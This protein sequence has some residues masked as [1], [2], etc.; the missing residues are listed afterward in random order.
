[1]KNLIIKVIILLLN[2]LSINIYSQTKE[3]GAGVLLFMTFD[4]ENATQMENSEEK[5]GD[6]EKL[7]KTDNSYEIYYRKSEGKFKIILKKLEGLGVEDY[8]YVDVD[9]GHIFVVKDLL[10]SSAKALDAINTKDLPNVS[11][12]YKMMLRVLLK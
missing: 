5:Y 8:E 7:I 10:D 1:M 2:L 11:N 4:A 12:R 9:S 3:Y 6:V